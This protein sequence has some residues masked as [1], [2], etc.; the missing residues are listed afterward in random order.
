MDDISRNRIY[1]KIKNIN[2]FCDTRKM[3]SRDQRKASYTN[4]KE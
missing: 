1:N 2:I 4:K 3:E